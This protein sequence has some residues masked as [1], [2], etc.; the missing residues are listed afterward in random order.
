MKITLDK[1]SS[2]LLRTLDV[3]NM[4]AFIVDS[5]WVILSCND[6]VRAVFEY[7]RAEVIGRHLEKFM[8][9]DS[10]T[11]DHGAFGPALPGIASR[12]DG[13]ASLRAFCFRKNSSPLSCRVAVIPNQQNHADR[14][15]VVVRDAPELGRIYLSTAAAFSIITLVLT[16]LFVAMVAIF[17]AS[18]VLLAVARRRREIG[19]SIAIVARRPRL[20]RRL[21]A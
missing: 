8:S 17:V 12:D 4:P 13:G 3:L 18:T 10:L 9:L 21:A 1:D 16:V 5:R 2:E 14:M 20:A 7:D 19:T 11:R 15:I 6:H